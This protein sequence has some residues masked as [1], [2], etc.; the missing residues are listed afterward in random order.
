MRNRQCALRNRIRDVHERQQAVSN[1]SNASAVWPNG[2][3]K[4]RIAR[5]KLERNQ[6]EG[7]STHR[8][9]A[10]TT[11]RRPFPHC[12]ATRLQ[13]RLTE[14]RLS[15]RGTSRS[16]AES[17]AM[18][19]GTPAL[20]HGTRALSPA[21]SSSGRDAPANRV[22]ARAFVT[23][24]PAFS[25]RARPQLSRIIPFRRGFT[26]ERLPTNATRHGDR[27]FFPD[28][29]R[30]VASNHRYFERVFRYSRRARFTARA[31]LNSAASCA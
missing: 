23:R 26:A 30:P 27:R 17:P 14:H 5:G 21:A 24:A 22:G 20:R 11:V 8:G 28:A 10:F 9:R 2:T 4:S 19:H 15:E 25:R 18:A 29:S 1:A 3:A 6:C 7:D 16:R 12:N 13:R 31:L